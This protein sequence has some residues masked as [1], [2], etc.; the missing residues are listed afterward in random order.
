MPTVTVEAFHELPLV[1]ASKVSCSTF[2]G[3]REIAADCIFQAN[4]H[5]QGAVAAAILVI[6]E[7]DAGLAQKS[8]PCGA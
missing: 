7:I 3:Q 2:A 4:A 8:R 6:V 1:A 5:A